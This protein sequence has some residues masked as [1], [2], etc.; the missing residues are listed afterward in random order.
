MFSFKNFQVFLISQGIN[1]GLLHTFYEFIE[2]IRNH[3]T[4]MEYIKCIHNH[5]NL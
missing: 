1:F 5:Q 2:H 3:L 4:Q